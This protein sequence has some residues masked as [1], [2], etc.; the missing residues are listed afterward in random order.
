[1]MGSVVASETRGLN[2]SRISGFVSPDYAVRASPGTFSA[3][4][5]H[6]AVGIFVAL[7]HDAWVR[8]G[9][10]AEIR[11]R[12]V[13]MPP[14]L[15]YEAQ[16]PGAT[17]GMVFDPE[18]MPEVAAFARSRRGAFVV[19]GALADR[20]LAAAY[21]H[22]A[23]LSQA[24]VLAGFG[25]EVARSL[26]RERRP[27]D[28][29][30]ALALERLRADPR[31]ELPPLGISEAH[32]SEL[33]VRDVGVPMRTYRLWRK[34]LGAAAR[35]SDHDLTTVAHEAGF[36]DLA[37]LSRTCRRMLGYSPSILRGHSSDHG[38]GVRLARVTPKR[39]H[40]EK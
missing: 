34:L 36:A 28:R 9:D 30:V 29:R 16:S 33:F 31:V 12:V 20:W 17:L 32:L 39:E 5:A 10:G 4:H 40:R 37:H 13:V 27:I 8:D 14:D 15:A 6:H 22:R 24:D 1:M 35:V 23:S 25:D 3:M 18:T 7:E 38:G 26:P 11:G 19:E 2:D 21:A